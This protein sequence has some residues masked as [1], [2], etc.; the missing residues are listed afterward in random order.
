MSA[1]MPSPE[2]FDVVVVGAGPVGL[3]IA[4][5]LAAFGL[6][7]LVLEAAAEATWTSRAICISRRSQ[8]I[9]DRA[10]VG[11][12][13]SAQ[14]LPWSRGKTFHRDALAFQLEM[15]REPS[16][17]HAPFVNIQQ[18][19]TERVLLDRAEALG[20]AA[21]EIR[22]DHAVAEVVQDISGVRL[23]VSSPA[24]SYELDAAW[25]VAADGG[26]SRVRGS[27]GLSLEGSS[28]EGRYL[29]ADISV[30]APN[31]PVERLVWFDP[32]SNP[33]STV[34]LH[35]QP[36]D[37][38]RIDIQ[39]GDE[40]DAELALQD[41]KLA[42]RI[43]AHLDMMGVTGGWRMVWKSVYRAHALTLANYRHGRVM[44]AGDAAHLVPIFG[45]RGLNSGFDDA[46]NLAWKLALVAR[47]HA[48][49]PLLD[50]YTAERLRATRENLAAATKSTWFMSPPT[51]GFRVM[52]DA[53][54]SLATDVAWAGALLNPRQSSAHVYDT[55][56]VVAHDQVPVGVRPG[57]VIPNLPASIVDEGGP[58]AAHLHD[59]L[60]RQAFTLLIFRDHIEEAKVNALLAGLPPLVSPVLVST[61]SACGPHPAVIDDGGRLAAAFAAQDVPLY[62]V[63]PDEHVAARLPAADPNA[64]CAA[65]RLALGDSPPSG[66]PVAA[67]DADF[68]SVPTDL[69]RIFEALSRGLDAGP[70]DDRDTLARLALLL[71]HELAA[72]DRV[73]ALVAQATN[74]HRS[75]DHS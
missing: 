17:R 32:P 25:V 61:S 16:D 68:Q 26:R 3:V 18:Y 46:H 33:G 42:P 52:R 48:D 28:Y 53:V 21:L 20:A 19:R 44:F 8:E 43:Q 66:S 54:L 63:R 24:G 45:V 10:G 12:S 4:L 27:L 41:H 50:S 58:R 57:A 29:I 51:E 13:F 56:P 55:S 39:L 5:D 49:L 37:M 15:P 62:L 74:G 40:E 11:P 23:V 1:I 75:A 67:M 72:P 71:A 69:E 31:L 60:A 30:A 2:T 14:A 47:G 22:R 65:L 59:V 9:L 38:W 7:P 70:G 64:L 35:V 73:L 36:D 34:I 6:R